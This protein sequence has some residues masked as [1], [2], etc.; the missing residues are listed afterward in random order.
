[1]HTRMQIRNVP[2]GEFL[3]GK[4]DKNNNKKIEMSFQKKKK[5]T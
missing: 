3:F 4:I 2:N 1:M 5:K